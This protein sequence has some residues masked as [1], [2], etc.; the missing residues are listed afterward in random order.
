MYASELIEDEITIPA[1][2][3]F[4][5][6]GYIEAEVRRRA[7]EDGS[8]V[9]RVNATKSVEDVSLL[10]DRRAGNHQQDYGSQE[11]RKGTKGGA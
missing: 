2:D 6:C 8:T 5:R 7:R 11:A 9:E 4:D 10:S 3:D 1:R